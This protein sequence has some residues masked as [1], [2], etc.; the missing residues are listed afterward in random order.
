MNEMNNQV[1]RKCLMLIPSVLRFMMIPGATLDAWGLDVRF[2][3]EKITILHARVL[4]A[5]CIKVKNLVIELLLT[6]ILGA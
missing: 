1:A 3:L 5:L 4:S 6:A 2:S